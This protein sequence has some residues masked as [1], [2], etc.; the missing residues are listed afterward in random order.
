MKSQLAI[1]TGYAHCTYVRTRQQQEKTHH[2]GPAPL[3][4]KKMPAS[5][6]ASKIGPKTGTIERARKTTDFTS[7]DVR[8]IGQLVKVQQI[9]RRTIV[10]ILESRV[11]QYKTRIVKVKGKEL[12]YLVII[13]KKLMLS[14]NVN[15]RITNNKN[16]TKEKNENKPYVQSRTQVKQNSES[17]ILLVSRRRTKSVKKTESYYI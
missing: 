10:K 15:K 6:K 9:R 3:A 11:N 12:R 17:C 8:L 1:A 7:K 4:R 16:S 14:R 13:K 5:A 2:R